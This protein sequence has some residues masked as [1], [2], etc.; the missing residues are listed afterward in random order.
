MDSFAAPEIVAAA[1]RVTVN[2]AA[3]D[4]ATVNAGRPMHTLAHTH[5]QWSCLLAHL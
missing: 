5:A 2:R 3:S 4:L 1:A